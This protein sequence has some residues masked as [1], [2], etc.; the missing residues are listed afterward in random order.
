MIKKGDFKRNLPAKLFV[1]Y[2]LFYYVLGSIVISIFTDVN[3]NYI[4]LVFAVMTLVVVIFFSK[5]YFNNHF[6]KDSMEVLDKSIRLGIIAFGLVVL[7]IICSFL[8]DFVFKTELINNTAIMIAIQNDPFIV[9]IIT[10]LLL[11]F[12]EEIIFKYQLLN[13]AHFLKEKRIFKV[14]VLSVLF[15]GIHCVFELVTLN[16]RIVFSFIYYMLFYTITAYYYGKYDNFMM[17]VILH[18]LVNACA[19]IMSIA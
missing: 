18:M 19:F 7:N 9:G 5:E 10:I 6:F 1:F 11:P 12:T 3:S 15:A 8:T 13:N 2:L 4:R 14:I 17:S 16:Y